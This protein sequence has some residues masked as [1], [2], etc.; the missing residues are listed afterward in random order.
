LAFLPALLARVLQSTISLAQ[1]FAF[2]TEVLLRKG[3]LRRRGVFFL[4]LSESFPYTFPEITLFTF[5][6]Y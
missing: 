6:Y 2:R 1:T 5:T 3:P 4:F